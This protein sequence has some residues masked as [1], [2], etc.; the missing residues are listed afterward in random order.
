MKNIVF[1]QVDIQV[2][3][4]IHGVFGFPEEWKTTDDAN[5]SLF[6]YTLRFSSFNFEKAKIYPREL[7]AK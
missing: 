4:Q 7:T 1:P 3:C 6:N 5:P 2:N